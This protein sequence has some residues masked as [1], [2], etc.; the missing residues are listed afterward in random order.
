MAEAPSCDHATNPA[1]QILSPT[2]IEKSA[3]SA[4]LLPM[5]Q[6]TAGSGPSARS[7]RSEFKDWKS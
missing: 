1:R 5:Q 3:K 2:A 4:E 6:Q 7:S